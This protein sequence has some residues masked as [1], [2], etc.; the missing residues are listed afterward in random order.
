MELFLI[1]L[2][3]DVRDTGKSKNHISSLQE[4]ILVKATYSIAAIAV[5]KKKKS[6]LKKH[7]KSKNHVKAQ[8]QKKH[9]F[10]Y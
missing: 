1:T 10:S 8:K 3:K 7:L 2:K 6:F 4:N 5:G 9:P